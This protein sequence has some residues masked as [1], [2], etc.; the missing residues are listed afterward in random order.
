MDGFEAMAGEIEFDDFPLRGAPTTR[1]NDVGDPID[2]LAGQFAD[3]LEEICR[4]LSCARFSRNLRGV[5]GLYFR[6]FRAS[7]V[8]HGELKFSRVRRG[9][10][11]TQCRGGSP[12]LIHIGNISRAF[13]HGYPTPPTLHSWRT[14]PP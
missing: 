14:I 10:R 2:V 5:V 3:A 12:S 7:D 13:L 4:Q 6:N 1:E 8:R 11:L 9:C